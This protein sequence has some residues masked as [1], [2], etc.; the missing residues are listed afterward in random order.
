MEIALSFFDYKKVLDNEILDFIRE[1]ETFEQK[2]GSKRSIAESRLAYDAMCASFNSGRPKSVRAKDL[3]GNKLKLR[4]YST[5]LSTGKSL[6]FIHGGG[7]TLGG[8]DSHDDICADISFL[9]NSTVYALDYRLGPEHEHPSAYNDCLACLKYVEEEEKTKILLVGDSAGGNLVAAIA[10]SDQVNQKNLIGQ[11]LI[12]PSLGNLNL[13]G[14]PVTH[15]NAPLLSFKDI[16]SMYDNYFKNTLCLKDKT[17]RPIISDTLGRLPKTFVF[18]AEF[19]PL[20]D[21]GKNYCEL[22]N[23]QGGEATFFK[24]AGL[25]HMHLRARHRST[26]AKTEF[27][28]IVKVINKLFE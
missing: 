26:K 9:T 5:D 10:D 13:A 23:E 16:E 24:S 11:I 6:L 22:V 20:Y 25:V 28:K 17:A 1:C 7:H 27:I 15:V 2:G 14:T 4:R 21:D 8:L 12:Y 19:D 3:L 18:S